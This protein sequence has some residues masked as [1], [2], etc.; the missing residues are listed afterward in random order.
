M[1]TI[2]KTKDLM[3]EVARQLFARVGFTNTTM[4]DIADA[5]KKGRR[6]LYTYFRNKDEIFQAVIERE[7][8]R[9]WHDMELIRRLPATPEEK[10]LTMMLTHLDK[11]K[12][13][14]LRNGS[15][16]AEFFRDAWL[17]ERARSSFDEKEIHQL[18]DLLEEGKRLGHFSI[19]N[20]RLMAYLLQNIIK[21]MEVPFISGSYRAKGTIEEIRATVRHLILHGL[22]S[23]E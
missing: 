8:E 23:P 7:L 20:A 6:T 22:E 1:A 15:L 13:L 3:I 19:P 11:I 17:V 12:D 18:Q 14:V 10:I 21:G 5:S 16:R 9:L 2:V 4:N